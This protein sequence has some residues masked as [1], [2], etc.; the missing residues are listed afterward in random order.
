ME[1]FL[2]A[3][4]DKVFNQFL[5]PI[6]KEIDRKT[7]NTNNEYKYS[8]KYNFNNHLKSMLFLQLSGGVSLRDFDAKYNKHLKLKDEFEVPTYSQ[9]S[10]L[11]ASKSVENFKD[12]F[13]YVLGVAQKEI[14]SNFKTKQF[15]DLVA[16]D[17]SLV[18]V[19]KYFSPDLTF[20]DDKSAIRISTAYSYGTELPVNINIVPAKVGERKCIDN[21]INDRNIIYT[22]DKGY[23]GYAWFDEL[24]SNGYKFVTR[25]IS[26]GVTEQYG[27]RHTG[28]DNLYDLTVTL[29]TDYSKNKTKFKYREIE[30]FNEKTGEEFRLLTNIFDMPAHDMLSIYSKRW[31]IECFFKHIKQNMTIKH[32]LGHSLNAISIQIY[33]ALIVHIL[34]LILKNR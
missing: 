3:K 31:N 22:F 1:V 24:A 7:K 5:K 15:K 32:W 30:H 25:P 34:L 14:K 8:K 19:N 29:G 18:N 6:N 20:T 9:L 33:S 28:I 26:N 2:M 10:R 4:I 17:S 27:C 21:Y 16:I 11:N 23:N 13:N 12:I